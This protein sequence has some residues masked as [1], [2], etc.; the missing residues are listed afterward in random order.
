MATR[1]PTSRVCPHNSTSKQR[2]SH[3]TLDYCWLGHYSL[4]LTGAVSLETQG[5][6]YESK[7]CEFRCV[8][9]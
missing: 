2:K 7:G 5:H 6:P 4:G 1:T 3:L 8:I 9:H